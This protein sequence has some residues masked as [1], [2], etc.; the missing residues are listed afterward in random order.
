MNQLDLKLR[1]LLLSSFK[2]F[3]RTIY[4]KAFQA[5]Y[6]ILTAERTVFLKVVDDAEDLMR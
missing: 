6:A 1:I 5:R 3:H 4:A 2:P